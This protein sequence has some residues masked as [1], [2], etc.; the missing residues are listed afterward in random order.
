M[1]ELDCSYEAFCSDV[2]DAILVTAGSET[3]WICWELEP[4]FN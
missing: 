1:D 2:E 3:H 4:F